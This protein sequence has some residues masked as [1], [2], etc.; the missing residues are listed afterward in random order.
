MISSAGE[1]FLNASKDENDTSSGSTR[2]ASRQTW[3]RSRRKTNRCRHASRRHKNKGKARSSSQLA[4]API[5]DFHAACTLFRVSFVFLL[6]E[7]IPISPSS[8]VQPTLNFEGKRFTIWEPKEQKLPSEDA[9]RSPACS[10]IHRRC[11]LLL[12]LRQLASSSWCRCFE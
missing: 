1:I 4:T 5:E 10:H 9:M 6:L 2:S 12:C 11:V 3:R 8:S 7:V